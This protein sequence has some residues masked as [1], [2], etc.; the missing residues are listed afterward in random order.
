MDIR[1]PVQT[2]RKH[3][4]YIKHMYVLT[5]CCNLQMLRHHKDFVLYVR[6]NGDG[7]KFAAASHDATIS[8]WDNR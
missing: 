5:I 3:M 8:L 6:Y 1:E 2:W 4:Y 7:T